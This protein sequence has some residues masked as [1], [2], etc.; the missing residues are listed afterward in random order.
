M[1]V[2]IPNFLFL[3]RNHPSAA[4]EAFSPE[5][6]DT[7]CG[8]PVCGG[9]W[10]APRRFAGHKLDGLGLQ[11][12]FGDHKLQADLCCAFPALQLSLP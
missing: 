7:P 4:S 2:W 1:W 11:P 8:V 6:L 10:W 12:P 5:L 9:A 3:T